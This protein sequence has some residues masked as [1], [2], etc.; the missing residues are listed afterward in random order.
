ME[1]LEPGVHTSGR[2]LEH[3]IRSGKHVCKSW[4]ILPPN[5]RRHCLSAVAGM[6]SAYWTPPRLFPIKAISAAC[7]LSLHIHLVAAE[8]RHKARRHLQILPIFPAR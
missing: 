7:S 2:S 5:R 4:T 3:K 8:S 6:V 1:D